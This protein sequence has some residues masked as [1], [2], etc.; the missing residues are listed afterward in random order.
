MDG[1]ASR[2]GEEGGRRTIGV[3]SRNDVEPHRSSSRCWWVRLD[4][5]RYIA[6]LFA[7]SDPWHAKLVMFGLTQS[8]YSSNCLTLED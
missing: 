7:P 3:D 5:P 4:R 2:R 1:F 6:T 8:I